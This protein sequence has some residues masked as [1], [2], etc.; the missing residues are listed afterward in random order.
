MVIRTIRIDSIRRNDIY[1]FILGRYFV[2]VTKLDQVMDHLVTGTVKRGDI[3]M[4]FPRAEESH[5]SAS[6]EKNDR[7]DL[8]SFHR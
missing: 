8:F 2:N 1:L 6:K 3:L 5:Y 4:L 7:L